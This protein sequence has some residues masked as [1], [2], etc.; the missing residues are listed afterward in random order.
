MGSRVIQERGVQEGGLIQGGGVLSKTD[1]SYWH[2][3][4]EN[5]L[6]IAEW[7]VLALWF[8]VCRV[9]STCIIVE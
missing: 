4:K 2:N 9:Y 5:H 8:V 3:P 1:F 6:K 7:N